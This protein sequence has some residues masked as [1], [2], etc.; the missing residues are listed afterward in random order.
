VFGA[1]I[2]I[3]VSSLGKLL[4]GLK[5]VRWVTNALAYYGGTS[6]IEEGDKKF[7]RIVARIFFCYEIEIVPGLERAGS[8][9]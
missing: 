2:E 7:C 6:A 8:H 5:R 3:L 9:Y 1:H 4:H